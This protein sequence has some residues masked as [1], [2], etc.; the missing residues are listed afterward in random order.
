MFPPLDHPESRQD[1]WRLEPEG[2]TGRDL[3]VTQDVKSPSTRNQS[4]LQVWPV[5]EPLCPAPGNGAPSVHERQHR[6]AAVLSGRVWPVS[7]GEWPV[8]R[9][10]WTMSRGMATGSWR[11]IFKSEATNCK[12]KHWKLVLRYVLLGELYFSKIWINS[13]LLVS[14]FIRKY[15]FLVSLKNEGNCQNGPWFWPN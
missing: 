15:R 14:K 13:Q 10:L 2:G 1:Q 5:S 9:W 4:E 12:L 3:G 8:I 6:M 7:E 11:E